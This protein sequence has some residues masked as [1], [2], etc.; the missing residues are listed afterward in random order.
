MKKLNKSKDCISFTHYFTNSF[1]CENDKKKLYQ[2]EQNITNERITSQE[3]K[4]ILVFCKEAF[5]TT[6]LMLNDQ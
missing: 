6:K 2:N 1:P 3:T 4:H 5:K